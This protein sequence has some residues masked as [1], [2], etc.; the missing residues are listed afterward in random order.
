MRVKG[1]DFRERVIVFK[2]SK[3]DFGIVKARQRE[4]LPK[5]KSRKTEYVGRRNLG[6]QKDML[7]VGW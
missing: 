4:F 6:L 7:K 3:E 5:M 2:E 1:V